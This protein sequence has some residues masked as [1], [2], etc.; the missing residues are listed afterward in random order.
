M[1]KND[2]LCDL[3]LLFTSFLS[4]R[5]IP[6]S[7][8]NAIITPIYKKGL[9]SDSANYRPISLTSVFGKLMERVIV[10]DMTNYLL[11][12]KLL[13][14]SQHGLLSKRFTLTNLIESVNNWTVSIK[15]KVHNRVAYIDFP[16]A[17]DSVSHA[18]L[19]YKLKSCGIDGVLLD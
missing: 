9:S 12:N 14:P 13:N 16:H 19:L 15:N 5:R 11:T 1:S 18:K 2:T 7:W 17:F 10:V 3:Q 8:K 4:V 6:S